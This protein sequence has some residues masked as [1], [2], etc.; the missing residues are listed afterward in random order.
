M[1]L[2]GRRWRAD[3]ARSRE[4]GGSGL[5]LAIAKWVVEAHSGTITFASRES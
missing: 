5:G 2:P 4:L 3:I 1:N